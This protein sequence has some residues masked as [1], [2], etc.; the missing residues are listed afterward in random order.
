MKIVLFLMIAFSA[1]A[2]AQEVT[3]AEFTKVFVAE[4][5]AQ[6]VRANEVL[7]A[8]YQGRDIEYPKFY[9]AKLDKRQIALITQIASVPGITVGEFKNQILNDF[10]C[11]QQRWPDLKRTNIWDSIFNTGALIKDSYL[12]TDT[13]NALSPRGYARDSEPLL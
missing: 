7:V 10:K 12:L 8:E 13:L 2:Q 4:V 5:N 3:P 9:C 1:Q 11:F 6:I